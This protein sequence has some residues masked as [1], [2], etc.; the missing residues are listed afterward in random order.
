VSGEVVEVNAPLKDKP[1]TVN[2]NPHGTWMVVIKLSNPTEAGALLDAAQYQ[3]LV[4]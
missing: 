2:A 4:K 1:E 3:D